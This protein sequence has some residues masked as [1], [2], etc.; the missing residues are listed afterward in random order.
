MKKFTQKCSCF[1]EKCYL[2]RVNFKIMAKVEI[3]L[4]TN[5]RP[6]SYRR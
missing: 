1:K 4:P 2:C 3:V 6:D 5:P